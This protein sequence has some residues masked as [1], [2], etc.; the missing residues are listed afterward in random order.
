MRT[1]FCDVLV[2]SIRRENTTKAWCEKCGSYELITQTRYLRN[3]PSVLSINAATVLDE[4]IEH[5]RHERELF[6][7]CGKNATKFY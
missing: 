7:T 5:W 1:S 3:L 6:S 4:E 2:S